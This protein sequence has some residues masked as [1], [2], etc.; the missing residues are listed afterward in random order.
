MGWDPSTRVNAVLDDPHRFQGHQALAHQ[1][2]HHGQEAVDLS[3]RSPRSRSRWEGRW[4]APGAWRRAAASVLAEAYGASEDRGLSQLRL[5]AHND[6]VI[7]RPLAPGSRSLSPMKILSRTPSSA[8]LHGLDLSAALWSLVAITSA[9]SA[10][11]AVGS[12]P[13]IEHDV[14]P[15]QGDN[16]PASAAPPG[17]TA[18][19]ADQGHPP[20]RRSPAVPGPGSRSL[21]EQRPVGPEAKE[22]LQDGGPLQALTMG[23]LHDPLIERL[24]PVARQAGEVEATEDLLGFALQGALR[25]RPCRRGS[26]GGW[27]A[28]PGPDSRPCCRERS[29]RRHPRTGHGFLARRWRRS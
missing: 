5:R 26:P 16:P 10:L 20:P 4:T 9:R 14:S 8:S 19:P 1:L 21:A 2:V 17:P 3:P 29:A 27:P 7:E 18:S 12:G 28:D 25:A 15:L 22:A 13:A 6:S 11:R 24:A 23:G